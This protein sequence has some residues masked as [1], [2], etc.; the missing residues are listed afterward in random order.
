[1]CVYVHVCEW[2]LCLCVCGRLWVFSDVQEVTVDS[3]K[4]KV[5]TRESEGPPSALV[6]R[7]S[8]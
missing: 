6:V 4:S 2:G 8:L 7:E 5:V 1:M 3:E